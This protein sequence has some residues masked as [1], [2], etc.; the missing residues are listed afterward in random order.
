MSSDMR[1]AVYFEGLEFWCLDQLV[2]ANGSSPLL[3]GAAGWG[4]DDGILAVGML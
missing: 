3:F 1:E 4:V 2:R